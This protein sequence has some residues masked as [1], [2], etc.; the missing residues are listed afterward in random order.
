MDGRWRDINP[1]IYCRRASF[2]H[3]T[4]WPPRGQALTMESGK[5]GWALLRPDIGGFAVTMLFFSRFLSA[6][7]WLFFFY[8]HVFVGSSNELLRVSCGWLNGRLN[9][10][11]WTRQFFAGNFF[12]RTNF[13]GLRPASVFSRREKFL[14]LKQPY[15][16]ARRFGKRVAILKVD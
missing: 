5:K 10:C 15:L 16:E 6:L 1:S 13:K 2:A 4:V 8:F 7:S 9:V 12:R 3:K 11:R 14:T